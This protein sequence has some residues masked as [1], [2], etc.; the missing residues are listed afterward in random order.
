MHAEGV[1]ENCSSM[2]TVYEVQ[3]FLGCLFSFLVCFFLPKDLQNI[4]VVNFPEKL[5]S[6]S[7]LQF[8]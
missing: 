4:M 8:C 1:A 2:T 7:P 5:F 6:H 3:M